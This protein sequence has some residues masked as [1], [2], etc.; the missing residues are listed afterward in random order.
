MATEGTFR[1]CKEFR[2]ES[3]LDPSFNYLTTYLH[4]LHLK[5]S[6]HSV[7][8]SG[9]VDSGVPSG[10]EILKE[11]REH[12]PNTLE[13]PRYEIEL[14]MKPGSYSRESD[15]LSLECY[16]DTEIF[17]SSVGDPDVSWSLRTQF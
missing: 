5:F 3:D 14:W 12:K 2:A 17:N 10:S 15:L 4:L 9:Q 1:L 6:V 13:S 11:W 16:L 7:K 8:T